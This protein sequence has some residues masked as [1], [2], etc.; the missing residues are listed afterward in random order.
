MNNPF[1]KGFTLIELLVVIAIIGI[2]SAV[3]LASLNTARNKGSDAAVQA[4]MK[5]VLTQS[6]I[7]YDNN[8]NK[9]NT[10]GVTAVA[11]NNTA[12]PTSGNTMFAANTTIK[13]AIAQA[14]LAG[15][16]TVTCYMDSTGQNFVVWAPLKNVANT[17]WCV[18]SKN[19]SKK[20]TS[21]QGI[22]TSCP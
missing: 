2:L 20:E 22:N 12:C 1:Q 10:D 14:A 19:I 21:T 15:G 7:F 18:D 9:Y 11:A 17:Y 16:G 4:N 13:N 6:T 5:T 3:V 8:A